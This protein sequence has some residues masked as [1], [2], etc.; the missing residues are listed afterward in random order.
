MSDTEKKP[1]S[2]AKPP[3][4]K[5]TFRA[6]IEGIADTW[7]DNKSIR[8]ASYRTKS[9]L[10]WIS[11][12]KV[13]VVTMTTVK[14]NVDVLIPL[15]ELYMSQ[16]PPGKTSPVDLLKEQ[17]F[18][19]SNGSLYWILQSLKIHPCKLNLFSFAHPARS[20]SSATNLAWQTEQA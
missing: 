7:E 15:C 10:Q 11:P 17:V 2:A 8:R 12:E 9:L 14:L 19:F 6:D 16:A 13:G 3:K 4:R 20:S 5:I 18:G 1:D